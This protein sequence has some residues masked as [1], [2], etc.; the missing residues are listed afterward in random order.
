MKSIVYDT[1]SS[2]PR[3]EVVGRVG[4][5]QAVDL[6][7]DLGVA[8]QGDGVEGSAPATPVDEAGH[9]PAEAEEPVGGESLAPDREQLPQRERAPARDEEDA[10]RLEGA[11]RVLAGA[12]EDVDAARALGWGDTD[13]RGDVDDEAVGEELEVDPE[14]RARTGQTMQPADRLAVLDGGG[15][16]HGPVRGAGAHRAGTDVRREPGVRVGGPPGGRA[17]A[18]ARR[19][20]ER[21]RGDQ[22]PGW[23]W[24]GWRP[25]LGALPLSAPLES[26]Y[27]ITCKN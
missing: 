18:S 21:E 6:E 14:A 8:A 11:E 10:G 7:H 27:M 3:R 22:P 2:E 19:K 26:R 20:A 12:A 5:Q 23:T 15:K 24:A 1:R 4:R 16:G 17:A 9:R 25:N 13:P